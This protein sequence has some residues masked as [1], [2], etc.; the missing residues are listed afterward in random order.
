MVEYRYGWIDSGGTIGN[1]TFR[2]QGFQRH[3]LFMTL[4]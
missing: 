2:L 3:Y 4:F 1:I